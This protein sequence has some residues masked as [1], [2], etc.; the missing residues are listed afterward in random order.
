MPRLAVPGHRPDARLAS[1]M[2]HEIP[3]PDGFY[4]RNLA[5]L[6]R[7]IPP[8]GHERLEEEMELLIAMIEPEE[9]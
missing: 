5:F 7:R 8:V 1:V 9:P 3:D 6:L 4:R 2:R